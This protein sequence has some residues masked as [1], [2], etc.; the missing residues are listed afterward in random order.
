MALRV[1]F[2]LLVVAL[3]VP[4]GTASVRTLQYQLW[5]QA[6]E[7]QTKEWLAGTEWH[8]DTVAVSP[9]GRSRCSITPT[10]TR[11]TT[12]GWREGAGGPGRGRSR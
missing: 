2:G 6:C 7:R 5:T 3:L 10:V 8:V 9:N 1:I 12:P 4:L 11:A